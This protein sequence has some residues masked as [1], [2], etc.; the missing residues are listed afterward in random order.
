RVVVP[1]EFREFI[2]TLAHD[3][4]LAGHLGQTKTWERL[5]NHFYWPNMSQKV[6]EFCV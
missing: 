3:I 1:Q 2:L 4:P 5:V 6:K